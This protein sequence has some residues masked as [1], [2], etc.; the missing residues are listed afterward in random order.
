MSDSGPD[1]EKVLLATY[2]PA[3]PVFGKGCGSELFDVQGRRYIDLAG[4]IA[5]N[6]LGH[7]SGQIGEALA[8][9]AG[10][11]VHV[12]NL[13]RTDLAART[14]ER[15]L[16]IAGMER[17]F[18][19]NSGAEANE[20]AIKCARRRGTAIDPA[21]YRVVSFQGSFHG[22]VGFA[23]AATGQERVRQGFGPLPEGFVHVPLN[24]AARLEQE[25]DERLGALIIEP[26]LGEGGIKR[27]EP[28]LIEQARR[29]CDR[30]DALLIFDEIQTGCGR[31]GSFFHYQQLGVVPDIVTTAKGL[32]G[33][34]PVGAMLAG[35][36]A[37]TVFSPGDHGTTFGG[38]LLAL[39]AVNAVLDSLESRDFLAEVARKGQAVRARLAQLVDDAG[40]PVLELRGCGLMLGMR[41][42]PDALSA[43]DAFL[44]A[45]AAGVLTAPAG[46]NVL[47]VLPALNIE[48]PI[49][50]EGLELLAGVLAGRC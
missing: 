3:P 5:V 44:R 19:A 17:L 47:R 30:H 23:L 40:S 6:L 34:L 33:G 49:L 10:R 50:Q 21:K 39:A 20:C 46:D 1:Y 24:D 29:L 42:D 13:F 43:K 25:C 12:S 9:Q 38:N 41:L 18:F 16:A 28:A 45:A 22:R 15:L 35:A 31:T 8:E 36:R 2:A 48:E 4:G 27:V 14:A 37:A 32:G 11:L 7:A 26:I